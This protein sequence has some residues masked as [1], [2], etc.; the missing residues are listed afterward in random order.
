ME[1]NPAAFSLPATL[2]PEL[3]RPR[4]YWKDCIRGKNAMPFSDDVNLSQ[5]PELTSRTFLVQVL[6]APE[7]FR[8]H[9]G[10]YVNSQYGAHL[11]GS[12]RTK[13]R[14]RDRCKS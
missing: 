3:D 5:I 9:V 7:R 14:I 6:E 10:E 8:L 11:K 12:S 4:I 13:L 1:L 2:E